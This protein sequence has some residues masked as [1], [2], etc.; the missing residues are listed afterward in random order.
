MGR[1]QRAQ[2]GQ[3]PIAR[4]S[5]GRTLAA[6]RAVARGRKRAG[7]RARTGRQSIAR[8]LPRP[9]DVP[10]SSTAQRRLK[11][12]RLLDCQVPSLARTP[13]ARPARL[14]GPPASLRRPSRSR[15]RTK[16]NRRA[17]IRSA[18]SRPPGAPARRPVA[19]R[20]VEPLPSSRDSVPKDS[21]ASPALPSLAP[22]PALTARPTA[23]T[24]Q[25]PAS[26]ASLA[27]RTAARR[28]RG[29]R[30]NRPRLPA[31][32]ARRS[33]RRPAQLP[34][35]TAKM[36]RRDSPWPRNPPSPQTAATRASAAT[37]SAPAESRR[38][39]RCQ[40]VATERL[41]RPAL[42]PVRATDR[43]P[44]CWLDR[45]GRSWRR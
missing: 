43:T 6:P 22:S 19:Q 26:R 18:E 30:P 44:P 9:A 12:R 10:T 45:E 2:L 28:N 37:P 8:S 32:T 33:W 20:P 21:S 39:Q 27:V 15:R 14:L 11:S 16:A 1:T 40:L 25:S 5:A 36:A 3:G 17:A 4:R 7:R 23:P 31:K 24:V 38:P 35:P 42:G 41:S 29:S 34:R 13:R